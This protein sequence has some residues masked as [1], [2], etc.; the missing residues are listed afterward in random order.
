M[1][2]STERH[3]TEG[4]KRLELQQKT[5]FSVCYVKAMYEKVTGIMKELTS[6]G[7]PEAS[8][9]SVGM[10]ASLVGLRVIECID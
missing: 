2:L 5:C 4:K 6:I 8:A 1:R 10:I 9:F 7:A 3:P